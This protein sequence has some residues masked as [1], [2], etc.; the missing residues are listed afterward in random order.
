MWRIYLNLGLFFN[1]FSGMGYIVGSEMAHLGGSWHWGLRVTPV[2][3]AI[4]VILIV[5]VM[6]DPE[7]GE[8][9]GHTQLH[10]TDY[11]TDVKDLL[12]K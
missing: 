6:H 4:A 2:L 11:A 9:E 5:F 3:G 7:R 10:H 8:A 1:D 12:T